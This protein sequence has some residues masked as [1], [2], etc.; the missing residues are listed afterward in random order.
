MI[1]AAAKN[2][3]RVGIVVDP[4]DY[5]GGAR[6]AAG[7]TA[8]SRDATRRRLA[9]KA[10][11]LTVGL[12]RR[13]RRVARRSR[14]DPAGPDGTDD[15]CRARCTSRSSG[16]RTCATARTPTRRA[17][18]TGAIG[19]D[20]AGGTTST[21]H[22]GLALS[23]LNLYDA[24]AGVGAGARPRGA[25]RPAGG[26]HHQAR[27]PVRRRGGRRPRRR[28]PAGLRVRRALGLRRHRGAQPGGRRGAR[29]SGSRRP[30]RPTS[31]SPP[32]TTTA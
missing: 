23:Y 4:A 3:A 12:R 22:G 5:D 18:A 11:A 25:R 20:V 8:R 10:F 9:R 16:R 13:D 19:V 15:G 6:R 29:S 27:Q 2:H 32:A 21:Q 17:P 7:P 31:S 24:D 14:A 28:L 1:R 30:P 26:R